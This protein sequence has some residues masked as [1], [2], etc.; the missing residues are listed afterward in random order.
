MVSPLTGRER[1]DVSIP[2]PVN[3]LQVA[4]PSIGTV[5]RMPQT[6]TNPGSSPDVPFSRMS[7]HM[8]I[9]GPSQAGFAFGALWTPILKPVGGYLR[10]LDFSLTISGSTRTGGVSTGTDA[11]WAA[12]QNLFLRDP[13][14][15]PIIQC[16]GYSLFLINIYGGQTGMLGFGNSPAT[17]PSFSFTAASENTTFS[18]DI[19]LELDSSG[20]GSQP[21][22]NAS[23]QP[24]LQVQLNTEAGMYA[25]TGGTVPSTGVAGTF[26]LTANEPFWG[27]PVDRPELA[28]PD[29]GSSGQWSVARAQSGVAS[30]AYQRVVLPRVGT[31][32]HTL[33][34]V[35]R[36]ST[37]TR[38]DNWP[39]ADLQLWIDGVPILMET[40][41]ER[42]DNMFRQFGVTRPTGV[43]VYT[44][45]N[46]V[47]TAI[48]TADTYD[49]LLP[50]TPATLLEIGGT[51][52]VIA[53]APATIQVITGELFPV[54]GIPYTHLAS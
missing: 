18:L 38:I 4:S 24:Q 6:T 15:Q 3:T 9:Q 21:S 36:D 28:P 42:T 34:L 12:V 14:G 16:D 48:S 17:M 43:I 22:M 25:G 27:A 47:Q 40:L 45:R 23:S 32:V 50:T 10:Y 44:F 8:Q 35:L 20:Y 19:P 41:A 46:S 1:G 52:G 31:W 26:T 33:I 53:S 54:G 5:S 39:A 13:F 11:P 30:N 51:F 29:V 7:R 2:S 49:M 37:N